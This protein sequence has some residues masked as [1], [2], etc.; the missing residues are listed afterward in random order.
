MQPFNINTPDGE[1][2]FAWHVLPLAVYAKN[3]AL[4]VDE[5]N[6]MPTNIEKTKAFKLL[7]KV[8][9]SCLVINCS[10]QPGSMCPMR[11]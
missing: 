9:G 3:E 10:L 5:P 8:P 7:A 1:V 11:Y 4:L 2:L 6:G